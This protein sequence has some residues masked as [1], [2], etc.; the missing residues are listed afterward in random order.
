[1]QDLMIV[2][3]IHSLKGGVA[4][5]ARALIMKSLENGLSV[6]VAFAINGDG[7][8][9]VFIKPVEMYKVSTMSFPGK[10]MLF[11]F[12]IRKIYKHFKKLHPGKT[13]IIHAHNV[14]TVGVLASIKDI[15]IV[16]TVHGT[17][18][19]NN[20]FRTEVSD[21]IYRRIINKIIDNKGYVVFV[22]RAVKA[23]WCKSDM[24][25]LSVIYNG[26][27]KADKERDKH[28]GFNVGYIGDISYA[29]GS[30]ILAETVIKLPPK[31]Q[32]NLRIIIAGREK[33]F[34]IAAMSKSL[35]TLKD[36]HIEFLGYNPNASR[37]INPQLDVFLLPSRNEGLSVCLIEAMSYGIPVIGTRVG[38][39]PEIIVDGENG[40]LANDSEEMAQAIDKIFSDS[41]LAHRLSKGSKD[42][43]ERLF[44]DSKMYHS[45]LILYT[46]FKSRNYGT[47]CN[48]STSRKAT[49]I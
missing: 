36:V 6:G 9:D 45:Y 2:H 40:F 46:N 27:K 30:D 10:N 7:Y 31:I 16:C 17:R 4:S 24:D 23:F 25:R 19:N 1:M 49:L 21:A 14:E 13:I 12:N 34:S 44:M 26:C 15:P 35:S 37:I 5:V 32:K 29:K 3:I 18:G 28:R 22:S 38:G 11:G 39:I 20:S 42:R 47:K 33:D 43:F 41:S 8:N 48:C